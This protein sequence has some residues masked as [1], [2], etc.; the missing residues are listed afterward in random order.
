MSFLNKLKS[1]ISAAYH[2]MADRPIIAL[3][4]LALL[5]TFLLEILSR[6][7]LVEAAA[8]IFESPLIF[9]F[10][11]L[12][13]LFTLLPAMF[14]RRRRFS[15]C[16]IAMLWLILGAANFIVLSYRTTPLGMIDLLLM[17]TA[18]RMVDTYLSLFQIILILLGIAA[19]ITAAVLLWKHSPKERIRPVRSLVSLVAVAVVIAIASGYSAEAVGDSFGNLAVAYDDLGFAYCFSTS[20]I[21]RGVEEPEDYS[22]ELVD[23]ISEDFE[24]EAETEDLTANVI[25]IQLESFFD[26]ATYAGIDLGYDPIPVFTALRNQ[27]S[28]GYLSMP[29]IG[30]GTANSEFEVLTGMNMDHFGAGEY[31]YKTVLL[32]NTCESMAYDFDAAGYTTTAIHNHIRS[33][34]GRETVY[35]NLGFDRFVSLEDM[36]GISYTPTGWAKDDVLTGEILDALDASTGRDFIYTVSVQAHGKYTD[37]LDGEEAV[38]EPETEEETIE[39]AWAYYAEQLS[40]TDA[41]VGELLE[42]L[43]QRKERCVVVLFGDHLPS[44]EIDE[45]LLDCGDQFKT[46]YIIWSNF[47]LEKQ[48]LDLQAYQLGAYVQQRLDLCLGTVT[49]LHQEYGWDSDHEAYQEALQTIEYDML[50]GEKYIFDQ[51]E[52]YAPTSLEVN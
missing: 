50:Y 27:H 51:Q 14:T 23:E 31:P 16:V 24:T 13:V 43:E 45:T 40:G 22:E 3:P 38:E 11:A 46:E 29:S 7:G 37:I 48:D 2:W 28:N 49:A 35:E 4:S 17:S 9:A 8:F 15:V 12:I 1:A 21:D 6:R 32:D 41:F 18:L 47:G 33:F 44:L 19:V 25:F 30:A 10:N 42:A 36:E 26:P 20:V 5:L 34:Y 52:R 39:Q